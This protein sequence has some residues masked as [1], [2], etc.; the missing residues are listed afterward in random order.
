MT[1]VDLHKAEN[2]AGI[3]Q[4]IFALFIVIEIIGVVILASDIP[5]YLQKIVYVLGTMSV[6]SLFYINQMWRS[7]YLLLFH[8]ADP[9]GSETKNRE[10][11]IESRSWECENNCGF[12]HK[13]KDAVETH[14]KNCP[15]RNKK[16]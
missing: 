6:L 1:S 2:S 15:L 3:V 10:R 14:E 5:P 11:I 4:F 7:I 13:E 9:T 16:L 8:I 12:R